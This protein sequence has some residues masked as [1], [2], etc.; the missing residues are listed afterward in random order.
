MQ[1]V[2][3]FDITTI[4]C[5]GVDVILVFS[6]IVFVVFAV[7]VNR[8]FWSGS[9]RLLGRICLLGRVSLIEALSLIGR[10]SKFAI[11]LQYISRSLVIGLLS[12]RGLPSCLLRPCNG[13]VVPTGQNYRQSV[14]VWVARSVKVWVAWSFKVWV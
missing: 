13:Q 2:V 4:W 1:G 6:I 5:V 8:V 3:V 14:K 7:N 12:L 11:Y 10:P 9:R